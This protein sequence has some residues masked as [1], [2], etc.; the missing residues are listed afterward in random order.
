MPY[1]KHGYQIHSADSTMDRLVDSALEL[2][3]FDFRFRYHFVV[4]PS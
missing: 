2:G 1:V 4:S 3:W